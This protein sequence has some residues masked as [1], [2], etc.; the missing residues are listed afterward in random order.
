MPEDVVKEIREIFIEAIAAHKF[1][2]MKY[3][4]NQTDEINR[5][6]RK[7]KELKKRFI[8]NQTT[9][10]YLYFDKLNSSES[11]LINRLSKVERELCSIKIKLIEQQKG[12]SQILNQVEE[13]LADIKLMKKTEDEF[14]VL[15]GCFSA[16]TNTDI[17]LDNVL[18]ELK[19]QMSSGITSNKNSEHQYSQSVDVEL[20]SLRKQLDEM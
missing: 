19:L 12:T 14:A 15:E 16:L 18:A 1:I 11:D 3:H 10:D 4:R 5:L 9:V 13:Q 7:W 8:A 17:E 2:E 6:K 20:D